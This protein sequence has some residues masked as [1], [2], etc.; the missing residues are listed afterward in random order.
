MTDE[1]PD[2]DILFIEL[3]AG[4]KNE[5]KAAAA[6]KGKTMTKLII[7]FIQSAIAENK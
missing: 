3:P 1:K 4:L 2:K 6:K 5:F 7:E